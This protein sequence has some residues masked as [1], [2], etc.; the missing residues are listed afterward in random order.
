MAGRLRRRTEATPGQAFRGR[1][2]KLLPLLALSAILAS[3]GCRPA[4]A[5][6]EATFGSPRDLALAFLSALETRD[7]ERLGALPLSQAEFEREVYPEMPAATSIPVS[8][9]WG[10]LRQK[11]QNDL[12]RILSFHGGKSYELEDLSFDGEHTSYET[13]VVHRRPRLHVRDRA[14]GERKKLAL[15]GSILEYGRRYKLFSYVVSK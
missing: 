2:H 3:A 12:A 9:V 14:T 7:V 15:L 5:R 4:E 8:Y 11:S 10:D 6:F 1:S 13:F